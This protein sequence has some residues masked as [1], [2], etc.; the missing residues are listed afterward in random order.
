MT[1]K[2]N[3]KVVSRTIAVALG[4]VCVVLAAGL[5]TVV[6]NGTVFGDQQTINELQAKV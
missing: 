6:V 3:G 4:L 5:V 2:K 1:D